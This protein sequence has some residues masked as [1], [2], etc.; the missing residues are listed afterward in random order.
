MMVL[1]TVER[2]QSNSK[3]EI[4]PDVATSSWKRWRN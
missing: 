4:K 2:K 1:A 3:E